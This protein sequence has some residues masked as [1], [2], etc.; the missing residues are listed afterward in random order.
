MD[1]LSL[2]KQDWQEFIAKQNQPKFRVEQIFS[3]LHKGKKISEISSLPK[4]LI[5]NIL[6]E[7]P[8]TDVQILKTFESGTTKKYLYKLND[9]NIIEGVLMEYKH[10]NTLCVSTQVGCRMGCS[11]CASGLNGLVRN[12]TAGEILAQVLVVNKSLGGNEKE[13][14]ITNLVLMGSGEPLDNYDN[15][16]KFIKNVNEI[17]GINISQRNISLSTCGLVEK[18]KKLADEGF[19]V[20]LSLSLHAPTD[21]QRKALMKIA[22]SYT[23]K[24]TINACKYYFEKTGRRFIIEYI[25]IHGINDSFKDADTL[26]KILKGLVCHVNVINLNPV[27]EKDFKPSPRKEM[28]AFVERLLQNGTSASARRTLGEEIDGACGQLRSK[29]VGD[30]IS[31]ASDKKN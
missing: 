18:I 6:A 9:G 26:S 28:Y 15:V 5:A 23:I 16:V 27:K 12:L 17:G 24:E 19:S 25:L 10:G 8:E 4:S 11:F 3:E 21:E 2:S 14:K 1:T 20:N 31:A 7:F 30:S 29:Y 22:N 13:R